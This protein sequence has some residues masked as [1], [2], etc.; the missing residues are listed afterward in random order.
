MHARFAYPIAVL[1]G[2]FNPEA[3]DTGAAG[4]TTEEMGTWM[5]PS[6][7]AVDPATSSSPSTTTPGTTETPTS[8]PTTSPTTS[9]TSTT[10]AESSSSSSDGTDDC[11]GANLVAYINF[12]GAELELGAID[13][14]PENITDE[15]VLAGVWPPYA[16][17]DEAEVFETVLE[18]WAGYDICLTMD[19]GDATDYEMV[20]V[21][22]VAYMNNDNVLSLNQPDCSNV[23]SN[24]VEVLFLAEGLNLPTI[25]KAIAISHHLARMFGLDAVNA[26]G[27]LMNQFVGSTQN[28]A[29]F[30]DECHPFG[31]AASCAATPSCADD[32]QNSAEVLASVIGTR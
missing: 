20:V 31:N 27:D 12:G 32:E 24:N 30:T 26:A 9:M 14:A 10:S 3:G 25:T 6:T 22:S 4:S 17:G 19:P 23:A 21:Q 2:C 11:T 16:E 8:D 28:G 18:H 29:S 5:T 15:P 13:N 7:T 1:C